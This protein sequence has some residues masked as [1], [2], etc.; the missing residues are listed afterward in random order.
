MRRQLKHTAKGNSGAVS[1]TLLDADQNKQIGKL[2]ISKG[3]LIW[4][5]GYATD[6]NKC[7][8]GWD[9]FIEFMKKHSVK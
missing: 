5:D 8:V 3:S 9:A 2:D 6:N 1:C 7:R 4:Y